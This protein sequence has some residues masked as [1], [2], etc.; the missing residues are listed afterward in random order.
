MF[1]KLKKEVRSPSLVEKDAIN[2]Y[3]NDALISINNVDPMF[4][5]ITDTNK[6]YYERFMDLEHQYFVWFDFEGVTNTIPI[7]DFHIPWT[8]LIAQTSIIK[9][10][11]NKDIKNYEQ[12]YSQN[13]VYDPCSYGLDTF[14]KIVNDLYDENADAYVVFNA[15]Y[16]HSRLNEIKRYLE[17]YF[18]AGQISE[19]KKQEIYFKIDFILSKILDLERFIKIGSLATYKKTMFTIS[20]LKGKSSIKL[21]EKYITGHKE[22]DD[23]KHKIQPYA[24]LAIKNGAMALD[25]AILRVQGKIG[26]AEWKNIRVFKNLLSQWCYGNDYGCRSIL[27]NMK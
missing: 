5:K 22:Y 12:I 14:I 21:V 9:T 24:N 4:A 6:R 25:K 17:C 1:G 23:L 10:I 15:G 26:D 16:E 19:E 27:K 8:Q 18:I 3:K 11:W 13:H 2:F 20:Y 7:I